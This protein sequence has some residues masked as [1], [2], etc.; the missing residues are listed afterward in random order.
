ME[1]AG[2]LPVREQ[3]LIANFF[4]LD[5]RTA[6]SA[7]SQRKRVAFYLRD[8]TDPIIRILVAAKLFSNWPVCEGGLDHVVGC[9]KARIF[10]SAR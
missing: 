8:N 5:T 4:E 7:M 10:S 6:S 1:R 2:T 3:Q 9:V